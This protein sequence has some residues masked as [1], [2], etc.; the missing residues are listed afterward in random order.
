MHL[1]V[2]LAPFEEQFDLPAGLV[3]IGNGAG[4]EFE[5]VGQEGVLNAGMRV[6]IANTAE[7]D[8]AVFCLCAS[9][10]DGLVADQS[11]VFGHGSALNDTVT[12]VCF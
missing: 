1:Q 8:E 10:L 3:N 11:F 5:V 6:F 2:L 12:R 7:P 9:E 4:S